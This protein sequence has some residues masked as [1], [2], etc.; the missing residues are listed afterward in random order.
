M[1]YDKQILK[2]LSDVGD[3]GISVQMLAKHVYNMNCSLFF[4]LDMAEVYSYVR[5]YSARNSRSP[6]PLIES[7]GRRGYYRLNTGGSADARQLMLDFKDEKKEEIEEE[8]PRQDLSLDL[9]A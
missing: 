6:Q 2:I 3:G 8:K 9:F 7:T 5:L 4:T 1:E